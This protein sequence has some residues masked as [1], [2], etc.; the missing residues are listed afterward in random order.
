LAKDKERARTGWYRTR[1]T[2]LQRRSYGRFWEKMSGI[3]PM[4]VMKAQNCLD[5]NDCNRVR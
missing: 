1:R 4:T 5:E 2:S 3:E